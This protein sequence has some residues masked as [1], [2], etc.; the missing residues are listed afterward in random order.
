[1]FCRC[2]TFVKVFLFVIFV[3][4]GC[5]LKGGWGGGGIIQ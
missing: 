4:V 1:M 3:V 2:V 5:F